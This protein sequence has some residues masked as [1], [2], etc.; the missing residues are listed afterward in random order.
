MSTGQKTGKLKLTLSESDTYIYERQIRPY[1]PERIFD[2]HSH[3]MNTDFHQIDEDFNT[4]PFFYN[5]EMQDL[6]NWWRILFLN[7]RVNGLIMG[8][9]VFDCDVVA[10]NDYV[11]K[12]I[13]D[14][15]NRF[16]LMVHPEMSADRLEKYIQIYKPAGLKPYL[17][18]AKVNDQENANIT[19]FISEEQIELANKYKLAVTLH[20]SKTRGMADPDNLSQIRRLVRQYPD[21]QFILAHCGRCFISIN[22]QDA[23]GSLPVA[24]NL[25]IDTSAVCDVGVFLHL[26][27]KYDSG[28]ILFGTDLV[29]PT[30]F[31]GGYVGLGMGWHTCTYQMLDPHGKRQN[32]S[33]FAVYESLS[34]LFQAVRF[35][36]L[37]KKEIENIF[38]NNAAALFNF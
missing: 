34:A 18:F 10:E 14:S 20:V 7:V 28:R 36:K 21:C 13:T 17:L 3:L 25:W 6:E 31:R 15:N 5:V 11:S 22:M 24:E 38:Y 35:C 8:T 12:S 27:S 4:N 9:P 33:T 1:L 2:A 16:S 30:A 23:L 19:D 37:D 29:T 26:F 32:R